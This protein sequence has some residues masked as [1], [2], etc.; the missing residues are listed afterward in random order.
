M[1]GCTSTGAS[2]PCY[3]S[4]EVDFK[5]KIQILHTFVQC[6]L[7]HE[8]CRASKVAFPLGEAEE[9]RS[10]S[11]SIS[12]HARRRSSRSWRNASGMAVLMQA[13]RMLSIPRIVRVSLACDNIYM[14]FCM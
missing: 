12:K 7:Y 10:V 2:F 6:R 4:V 8:K 9:S 3:E 5:W 11:G 1:S 13:S 14:F